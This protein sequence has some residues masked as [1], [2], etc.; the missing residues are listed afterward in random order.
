MKKFIVDLQIH[1][2]GRLQKNLVKNISE[3]LYIDSIKICQK[4]SNF[5]NLTL[6]KNSGSQN[7]P[8]ANFNFL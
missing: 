7:M 3:V 6:K 1:I 5:M 2:F 4:I 8:S